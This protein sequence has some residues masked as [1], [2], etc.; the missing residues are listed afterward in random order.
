MR[1]VQVSTK[2]QIVLPVALRQ[3]LGLAAGAV[4]QL[5][6]LQ[7]G[8][9]LSVIRSVQQR[10]LSDLAGM[11][12]ARTSGKPRSLEDFDAATIVKKTSA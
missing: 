2:G 11:I 3:R 12:K 7:D 9:K 4:L 6:E 5:E 8:L 10:D 1:T